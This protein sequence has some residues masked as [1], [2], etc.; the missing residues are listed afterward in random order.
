MNGKTEGQK[1]EEIRDPFDVSEEGIDFSKLTP[2]AELVA[3]RARKAA[4]K[5]EPTMRGLRRILGD[6]VLDVFPEELINAVDTGYKVWVDNPDSYIPTE[7]ASEQDKNDS[8]HVMRAYAECAGEHGYTI[9]VLADPDPLLLLWRVTN[10]RG[11]GL[12]T[13]QPGPGATAA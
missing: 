8:L 6:V 13:D 1:A 5:R 3:A 9:R 12:K 11:H 10:R 7:F 2:P 4:E